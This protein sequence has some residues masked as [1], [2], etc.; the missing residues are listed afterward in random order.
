MRN[1]APLPRDQRPALPDFTPVPRKCNRHDGWTP[2]RQRA[3]IQALAETGSV[4]IAARQVN[5]AHAT[6]YALRHHP[7]A[8]SFRLAWEAALACGVQRLRDEA[9]DRAMNGQLQ[10]VFWKGKVVGYRRVKNDRLL[11][12]LLRHYGQ[13]AGGKRVTLNYFAAKPDKDGGDLRRTPLPLPSGERDETAKPARG[14][15]PVATLP[16]PDP[17]ALVAN[18]SGVDLDDE[19]QSQIIAAL[20]ACAARRRTGSPEDDPEAAFIA[21]A[22]AHPVY[23]G[24]FEFIPDHGPDPD[25]PPGEDHWAML[26]L[27]ETTPEIEAAVESIL[28]AKAAGDL[29]R[30]KE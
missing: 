11:M 25:L 2:E 4:T 9:F 24:E 13:D 5:M 19:A 18:F 1:K 23:F 3:F 21:P 7:E 10:P 14:E 30:E 15:G 16:A 29:D 12:Y 17:A 20:E 28:R 6:A 22:D 8:G 27:P 26:D